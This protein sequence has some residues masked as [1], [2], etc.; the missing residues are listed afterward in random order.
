MYRD[1]DQYAEEDHPNIIEL[2]KAIGGEAVYP[3]EMEEGCDD[4]DYDGDTTQLN[5]SANKHVDDYIQKEDVVVEAD[6][7][8]CPHCDGTGE[9]DDGNWYN[10][11]PCKACDGTGKIQDDG[12]EELDEAALS[13]GID[14]NGPYN[15]MSSK[16]DIHDT[17]DSKEEAQRVA[18]ELNAKHK[19]KVNESDDE[20]ECKWCGNTFPADKLAAHEET[21]D[22]VIPK[23]LTKDKVTESED[24][25]TLMQRTNFLLSNK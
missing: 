7:N 14:G 23:D 22:Y 2:Y 3:H 1:L 5:A 11:K 25:K 13:F 15:V 16:G 20:K 10:K 21:C 8:Q 18:K 19:D 4:L 17:Y 6:D 9:V 12:K 24:L